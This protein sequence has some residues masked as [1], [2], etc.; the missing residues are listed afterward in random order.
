MLYPKGKS[1]QG[2][3]KE[4]I[5]LGL[6]WNF[7]SVSSLFTLLFG[8]QEALDASVR[9]RHFMVGRQWDRR[10]K[11]AVLFVELPFINLG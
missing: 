2:R 1:L 4:P 10:T 8:R 5:S 11:L 6:K 3:Q 9:L 7:V